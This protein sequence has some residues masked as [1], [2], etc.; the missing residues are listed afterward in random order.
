[1]RPDPKLKFE[2][3]KL[4][5]DLHQRDKEMRT[6]MLGELFGRLVWLDAAA[7]AAILGALTSERGTV[8]KQA[9]GGWLV[10]M[11]L[12]YAL[13]LAASL[14]FP[15]T[16]YLESFDRDKV[17]HVSRYLQWFAI[18]CAGVATVLGAGGVALA[19]IY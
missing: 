13:S 4:D 11:V 1:M 14:A 15:M 16:R 3:R 2:K 19:L 5:E 12:L 10:L 17:G 8:L 9:A 6:R 7:V 18:V